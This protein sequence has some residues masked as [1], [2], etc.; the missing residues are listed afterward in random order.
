MKKTAVEVEDQLLQYLQK[1]AVSVGGVYKLASGGTG[2]Y[3]IDIRRAT[4]STQGSDL[5]GSVLSHKISQCMVK[6]FPKKPSDGRV[7]LDSIGG[8]ESGA[9]PL[10]SAI[11]HKKRADLRGFWVRKE[12]KPHGTEQ[13][14]E[15]MFAPSDNVI[16]IEDVV[17]TGAS[18]L[19]AAKVIQAERGRVLFILALID[20]GLGGRK[21]I[22]EAGYNFF[23]VYTALEVVG[24]RK[25]KATDQ[26]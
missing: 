21:A 19:E 24:L 13:R 18:C 5:V 17:T 2:G 22:E 12:Q 6:L 7:M 16:I 20:H 25:R 1:E 14:I 26:L 9:I 10:I 8:M 11:L 3:Y 4:M 15:G 23:N